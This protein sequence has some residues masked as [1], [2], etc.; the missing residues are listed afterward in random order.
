MAGVGRAL[1]LEEA[2]QNAPPGGGYMLV[3]YG[4]QAGVGPQ[5]V[6]WYW[7]ARSKARVQDLFVEKFSG[8]SPARM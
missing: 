4:G 5:Q 1:L 7:Q 3:L 2:P 8:N 6:D